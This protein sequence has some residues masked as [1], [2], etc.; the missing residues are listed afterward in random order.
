M[1]LKLSLSNGETGEEERGFERRAEKEWRDD[2][3]VA[4]VDSPS[5]NGIAS[6]EEYCKQV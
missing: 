2:R 4:G 5:P 6:P 3:D 1:D